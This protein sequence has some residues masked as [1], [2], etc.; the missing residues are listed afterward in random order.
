MITSLFSRP[1]ILFYL[2]RIREFLFLGDR[3]DDKINW[4]E[5]PVS[6]E[7]LLK[8]NGAK[9]FTHLTHFAGVNSLQV[10]DQL[11]EIELA[12][13]DQ[14]LREWLVCSDGLGASRQCPGC[15]QLNS[16][17]IWFGVC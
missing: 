11:K 14:L 1:L 9:L 5:T 13:S 7:Q 12:E 10:L 17:V 3:D 2:K 4:T 6:K 16:Q 15:Q 8:I